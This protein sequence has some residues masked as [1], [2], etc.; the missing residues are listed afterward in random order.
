MGILSEWRDILS[1]AG[2][3][4]AYS[5]SFLTQIGR[6]M[7]VPIAPLFIQTLLVETARL[8][9]FTGLVIG[10]ASASTTVSAVFL[11]KLGDRIGF[12]LI[13]ILSSLAAALLY[14]MQSFATAGWQL[15]IYQALVGVSMGGIIP[16]ISA[17]LAK[18]TKSGEEG[19]VYGLDNSIISSGRMIAPL[20]GAGVAAAFGLRSA[21][22]ATAILFILA[23]LLAVASLPKKHVFR[24][25]L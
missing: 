22:T 21:F 20:L 23:A 1:T 14:L 2:V 4:A 3:K 11:G 7:I 12:R 13:T 19:A 6:M 24:E 16:A 17:L 25:K 10:V 15:L 18:L 5:M 9:T 8:N